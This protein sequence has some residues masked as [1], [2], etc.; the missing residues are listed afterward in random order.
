M[1]GRFVQQLFRRPCLLARRRHPPGRRHHPARDRP[2]PTPAEHGPALSQAQR[3]TTIAVACHGA[4]IL[5]G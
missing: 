5:L 2:Y 3:R 4:L 1:T